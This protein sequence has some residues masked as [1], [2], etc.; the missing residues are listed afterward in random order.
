MIWGPSELLAVI[1]WEFSGY[2]AEPYDMANLIGC[3][4]IEDPNSLEGELVRRF[5]ERMKKKGGFCGLTWEYLPDFIM[6][7]RFAWLSEWLR[8]KHVEMI[9]MQS[10]YLNLLLENRDYLKSVWQI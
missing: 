8:K 9:R 10:E 5:I 6:A 4:G 1:D 7:L 2:K 3:I